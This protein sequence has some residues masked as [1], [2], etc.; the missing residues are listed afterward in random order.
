MYYADHL[1]QGTLYVKLTEDS[2]LSIYRGHFS[3]T[4]PRRHPIAH[5]Q[6]EEWGVVRECKVWLKFYHYNCC[7]LCIVL[8][9]M[10]AIYREYMIYYIYGFI[11]TALHPLKQRIWIQKKAF[12]YNLVNDIIVN[13][14]YL[15]SFTYWIDQWHRNPTRT[16]VRLTCK[17]PASE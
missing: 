4:N 14:N 10:A 8:L 12:P 16:S 9:Y 1:W 6:G 13:D 3:L 15:Y 11:L 17:T 7:S 2:V 5:P